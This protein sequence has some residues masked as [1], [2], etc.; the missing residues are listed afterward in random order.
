MGFAVLDTYGNRK[1][2]LQ[3]PGMAVS[4]DTTTGTVTG[5]APSLPSVNTLI[6]WSGTASAT[7][8]SLTA[9]SVGQRV[10]VKNTGTQIAYFAHQSGS[11]TLAKFSNL[12]TSGP[13]PIAAG[14]WISFVYDGTYWQLMEHEQGA[15]IAVPYASGN[16]SSASGSWTVGSGSPTTYAWQLDGRMMFVAWIIASTTTAGSPTALWLA[17]PN[18]CVAS[19]QI[20]QSAGYTNDNSALAVAP[21]QV[22]PT[23]NSGKSIVLY[24]NAAQGAF[25][26]VANAT[27]VFGSLRFQVN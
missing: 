26:N 1:T 23:L 19:T 3:R 17:I 8:D 18:G 12:V 7:F 13:T 21:V 11:A 9:G 5:W 6:E 27:N 2:T 24:L 15:M 4:T 10:T 20:L 22:A 16:F 25:S 14:G